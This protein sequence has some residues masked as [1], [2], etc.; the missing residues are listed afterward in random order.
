MLILEKLY[1]T[2]WNSWFDIT[3]KKIFHLKLISKSIMSAQERKQNCWQKFF[4]FFNVQLIKALNS[5]DSS[6]SYGRVLEDPK[7]KTSTELFLPENDSKA[8]STVNF[9]KRKTSKT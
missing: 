1:L 7:T 5:L 3:K 9:K 8:S 6:R 2:S 4:A